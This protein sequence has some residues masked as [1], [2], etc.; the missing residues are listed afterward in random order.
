MPGLRSLLV[1]LPAAA[2]PLSRFFTAEVVRWAWPAAVLNGTE[3]PS[4]ASRLPA[5]EADITALLRQAAV[6]GPAEA[7]ATPSGASW[8][9][10]VPALPLPLAASL[11]L[12]LASTVSLLTAALQL[13]VN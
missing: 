2:V 6:G 4:P 8:G 10:A 1:Y 7:G 11:S 5:M 12:V 13:S 9:N 3:W